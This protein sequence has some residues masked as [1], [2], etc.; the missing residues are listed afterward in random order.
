MSTY[1]I[2]DIHGE[3]DRYI[4]MLQLVDFSADDTMYIL[5]DVIDRGPDSIKLLEDIIARPNVHMLLGNHEQMCLDTLGPVP[6]FGARQLWQSNG[7]GKT[8]SRLLYVCTLPQRGKI[9]RF[10]AGLPEFMDITVNGRRFHLV[11][12]YPG[13]DRHRRLWGRP[14]PYRPPPLENCTVIIGHTP[15]SLISGDDKTPLSIWHGNGVICIDCGCGHKTDLRRLACL[16]LEDM[17]EFYV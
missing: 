2:S 9:L 15:T 17:A 5:G 12:G 14:A 3:Y 6:E 16:R 7:G 1:C 10:M 11:H 13:D 4:K 8:R